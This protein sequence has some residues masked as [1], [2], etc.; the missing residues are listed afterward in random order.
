[1]GTNEVGIYSIIYIKM[2]PCDIFNVYN[3]YIVLYN[4]NNNNNVYNSRRT[5]VQMRLIFTVLYILKCIHVI[6]FN[7]YIIII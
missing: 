7:I 1:M 4:N 6:Y 2:Y 5:W 3:N